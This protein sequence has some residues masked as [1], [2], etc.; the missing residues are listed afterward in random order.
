[1]GVEGQGNARTTACAQQDWR[2][3]LRVKAHQGVHS[4][5]QPPPSPPLPMPARLQVNLPVPLLR[6]RAL[7]WINHGILV[8]ASPPSPMIAAE[9]SNGG[10]DSG[11]GVAAG[12]A[13]ASTRGGARQLHQAG[14]YRRASALP[15][16]LHGSRV[17]ELGL[18]E[19][20]PTQL[21][22]AID[23]LVS[24]AH[25]HRQPGKRCPAAAADSA[26]TCIGVT[27][28]TTGGGGGGAAAAAAAA[29]DYLARARLCSSVDTAAL[30]RAVSGAAHLWPGRIQAQSGRI[31][32]HPL[33]GP[34]WS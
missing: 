3:T 13:G 20:A 24:A 26:A 34:Q 33:W 16:S 22:T 28:G 21:P 12:S 9:A 25:R 7:F 4:L 19:D 31:Q 29:A 15:A 1:M 8:L 14:L 5:Q 30:L 23:S 10:G 32:A 18:D 6:R 2:I 17:V 11:S 27:A